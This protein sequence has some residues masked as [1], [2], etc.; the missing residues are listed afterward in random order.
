LVLSTAYIHILVAGPESLE[1]ADHHTCLGHV[2]YEDFS[3]LEA[4]FTDIDKDISKPYILPVAIEA[5]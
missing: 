3:D 2:S 5:Y 4:E 1:M